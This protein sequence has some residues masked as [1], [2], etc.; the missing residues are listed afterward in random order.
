MWDL[1]PLQENTNRNSKITQSLHNEA[2][3][4]IEATNWE[5]DALGNIQLVA[6]FP[7]QENQ[8]A[9]KCTNQS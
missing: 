3:S 9:L 8:L 5:K 2:P 4:I 1:R 6:R 7:H